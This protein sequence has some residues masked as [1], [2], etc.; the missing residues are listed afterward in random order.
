MDY[1]HEVKISYTFQ[2][3][4]SQVFKKELPTLVLKCITVCLAIFKA[5]RTIAKD[6]K[7]NYTGKV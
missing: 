2:I 1:I 3:Q 5:L 7:M 4:T 6:L